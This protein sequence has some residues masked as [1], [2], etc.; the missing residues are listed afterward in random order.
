MNYSDRIS[1]DDQA[2]DT[3][4]SILR[5]EGLDADTAGLRLAVERGGC[6]GLSY[7]FE[8]SPEPEPDDVICEC[9][10]V[11]LFVEPASEPYLAGVELRVESTAHGTGFTI[12]NPNATQ[13]CGCGLSFR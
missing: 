5:D 1:L 8:L 7:S 13:E 12:D 9:G 4:R 2:A 3:I 11:R 6:A 10:E